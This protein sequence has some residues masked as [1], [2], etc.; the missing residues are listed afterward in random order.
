MNEDRLTYFIITRKIFDS[1]IWRDDPHILKL[2]IYLIG[3]AMH[4]KESKKYNSFEIKRGELVTSLSIIA[5]DNEYMKFGKLQRWS[6]AKVSRMLETLKEQNYIEIIS[7]TYGTHIKVC[8]YYTYQDPNTYKSDTTET[9]LKQTC[10]APET[11]LN[12][13]NND[14]HVNNGNNPVHGSSPKKQVKSKIKIQQHYQLE[15]I[16]QYFDRDPNDKDLKQFNYLASKYG[17]DVLEKLLQIHSKKDGS[18]SKI[19]DTRLIFGRNKE[20]TEMI[21]KNAKQ[22]LDYEKNKKIEEQNKISKTEVKK[23]VDKIDLSEI[24]G[25][26]SESEKEKGYDKYDLINNNRKVNGVR[27]I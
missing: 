21:F 19:N 6:R 11:K 1:A 2:F 25:I 13:N 18:F 4:S 7:D 5:D 20:E 12:I 17:K 23:L 8:N 22:E 24:L 3:H 26:R 9:Q 14:K 16:A 27:S 10:N 15:D